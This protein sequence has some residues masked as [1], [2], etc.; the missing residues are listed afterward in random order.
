[1]ER[2]PVAVLGTLAEFHHE[3]IPYDMAALVKLVAG[4]NPDLLC[5]DVAPEQWR[6]QHFSDLPPEYREALLPLAYQTDMVV[7]P[8]GDDEP[9]PEARAAGW[10]G[11][12]IRLLRSWLAA[13]QRSAPGP[14]AVNEGSRHLLADLL[15]VLIGW[16]AGREVRHAWRAHTDH[17]V[18]QVLRVTARD[19]G[20]RLLVVVNV[21][22][23][24]HIRHALKKWPQ[25]RLVRYSEL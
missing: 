14:A 7:V 3:P 8:V 19:P 11:K 6:K 13:L 25:M 21:Q 4:L 23:C 15:Y 9:L 17:L 5:V 24:H 16:L 12:A 1:M 10:R 22:H 20:A 18:Q 2:T